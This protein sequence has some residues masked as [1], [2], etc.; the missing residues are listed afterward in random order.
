M[1]EA[2]AVSMKYIMV[3]NVREGQFV[4]M[5]GGYRQCEVPLCVGD[6]AHAVDSSCLASDQRSSV[7]VYDFFVYNNERKEPFY[8]MPFPLICAFVLYYFNFSSSSEYFKM[9]MP[10]CSLRSVRSLSPLTM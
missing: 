8:V 3:G 5:P 6:N 10:A 7:L 1:G 2:P 4:P 9:G